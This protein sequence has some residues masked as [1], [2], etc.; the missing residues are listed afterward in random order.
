LF[1][2]AFLVF[3]PFTEISFLIS[4]LDLIQLELSI[5]RRSR[6]ILTAIALQ[7]SRRLLARWSAKFKIE[8]VPIT[9]SSSLTVAVCC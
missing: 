6:K 9:A 7:F 2:D 1:L 3:K 8:S 5:V 4:D